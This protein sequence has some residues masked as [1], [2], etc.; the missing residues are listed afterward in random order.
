MS[1]LQPNHGSD[2]ANQIAEAIRR[3]ARTSRVSQ[4]RYAQ[5]VFDRYGWEPARIAEALE[6]TTDLVVRLIAA[7][8][9]ARCVECSFGLHSSCMG[10]LNFDLEGTIA[11]CGCGCRHADPEFEC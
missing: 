3:E 11:P 10:E 1:G 4:A 9:V 5:L 7:D 8:G 2:G 6:I